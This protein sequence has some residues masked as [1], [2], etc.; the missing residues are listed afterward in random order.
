MRYAVVMAGGYGQRLWPLS[1]KKYPKQLL[2]LFDGQSL[3][4]LCINRIKKMFSYDRIFVVTG[5]EYAK[6]VREHV[7]Q[8]PT[9]NVLCEPVGRNTANAIGLAAGI[10]SKIDP[11]AVMAVFSADHLIE[12]D[13]ELHKAL[14]IAFEFISEQPE[15][16]MTLGITPSSA[17]ANYGYLKLAEEA[18]TKEVFRV[19]QFKEKPDMA[20]AQQYYKSDRFCWN[21]GMFC[22]RADVIL[23]LLK[24]FLPENAEILAEITH[25]WGTNEYQPLLNTKFP[26]LEQISVDHGIL[27]NAPNIYACRLDCRWQ[28][29]GSF[30]SLIQAVGSSDNSGNYTS[31]QADW[32]GHSCHDNIVISSD[33]KQL[34]AGINLKDM[35]IIQTDDAILICPRK[36][37][38][39]IKQ[40][41]NEM[42]KKGWQQYL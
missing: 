17:D 29:V 25:S 34:I 13:D 22:W 10:I 4:Q 30:D 18:Q 32:L 24:R 6:I 21:S 1:R 19:E 14:K 23:N 15:S 26:D 39:Q 5:T 41:L 37:V 28:D 31:A 20:T 9:G 12:P 36:K 11:D 3:L 33:G 40:L 7:P 27:E 16:L 2:E 35:I 38:D 42:R 8:I